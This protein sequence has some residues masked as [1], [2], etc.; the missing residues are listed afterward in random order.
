MLN[1]EMSPGSHSR[2]NAEMSPDLSRRHQFV[3][4]KKREP[5]PDKALP[6]IM[7]K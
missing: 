5:S 1:I 6:F 3:S 7:M 4:L 2:L